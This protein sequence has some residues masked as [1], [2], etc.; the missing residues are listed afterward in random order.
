MRINTNKCGQAETLQGYQSNAIRA[1]TDMKN[2]DEG[3]F[4]TAED[5][6]TLPQFNPDIPPLSGQILS[7][8]DRAEPRLTVDYIVLRTKAP[9][10][11][12][13]LRLRE[14]V[15]AGMMRRHGKGKGTWYTL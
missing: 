5:F 1:N 13:R 14:M 9:R 15:R 7:L 12:I 10:S 11:T 4:L 6:R 3:C 8:L 2:D